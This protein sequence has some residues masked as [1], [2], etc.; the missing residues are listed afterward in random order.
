MNPIFIKYIEQVFDAFQHGIWSSDWNSTCLFVNKKY[1]ELSG[2]VADP[3]V[4]SDEIG[5]GIVPNDPL[6]REWREETGRLLRRI[7]K[8]ADRVVRVVCGLP[9]VIK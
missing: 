6:E 9:Q 2:K 4:I 5:N 7:A 3:A 8:D 1:E